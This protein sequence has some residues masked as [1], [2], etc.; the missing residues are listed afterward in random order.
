MLI[1]NLLWIA[2]AAEL[3]GC[4]EDCMAPK[5]N[6]IYYLAPYRKSLLTSDKE[7]E[8]KIHTYKYCQPF[9]RISIT[10]LIYEVETR[11]IN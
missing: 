11:D 2:T 7:Q 8:K 6:N 10:T 3:N 9:S 4:D 1:F 5:A